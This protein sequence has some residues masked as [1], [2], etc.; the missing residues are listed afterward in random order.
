VS[1]HLS[2]PPDFTLTD[3]VTKNT[4]SAMGSNPLRDLAALARDIR[5]IGWSRI[6]INIQRACMIFL[7]VN[8]YQS[9]APYVSAIRIAKLARWANCEVYFICEPSVPEFV[10]AV[11][12]FSTQTISL[13]IFYYAG[14][15]LTYENLDGSTALS[16]NGGTVGPDLIYQTMDAKPTN[17]RIVW[18]MDGVIKPAAWDPAEQDL[19]QPGVLFIAPYADPA[20]ARVQQNDLKNESIF[21]QELYTALKST[22]AMTAR[23]VVAKIEPELRRFGLKVFCSSQPKEFKSEIPLI[24]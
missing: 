7:D 13:L 5:Q 21:V 15:V 18:T 19:D 4:L 8:A 17:L 23:Q 14:R 16:V 10:D 6:P 24:L 22:P 2:I 9:N 1:K 11:R 20:Q 3:S 12:H